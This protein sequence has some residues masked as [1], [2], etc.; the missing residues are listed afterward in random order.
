M[1]DERIYIIA[2]GHVDDDFVK[3]ELDG[4]NAQMKVYQDAFS[5]CAWQDVHTL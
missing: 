4:I 2:G 5:G 3:V 1:A